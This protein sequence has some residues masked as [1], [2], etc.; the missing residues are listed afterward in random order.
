MWAKAMAALALGA[1]LGLIA[2]TPSISPIELGA[3]LGMALESALVVLTATTLTTV[4]GTDGPSDWALDV[5]ALPAAPANERS[6]EK[7]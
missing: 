5:N 1:V 7:G 3:P 4:A 2:R 6:R